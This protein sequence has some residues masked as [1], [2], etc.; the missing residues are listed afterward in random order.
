[1][2]NVPEHKVPFRHGGFIDS[3]ILDNTVKAQAPEFISPPRG[4]KVWEEE[5]NPELMEHW[6]NEVF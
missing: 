3:A 2:F 4:R 5:K 1:M 6:P